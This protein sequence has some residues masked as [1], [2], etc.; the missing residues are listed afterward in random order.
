MDPVN[1]EKAWNICRFNER[2]CPVKKR[3]TE[4]KRLSYVLMFDVFF[5]VICICIFFSTNHIR[6]KPNCLSTSQILLGNLD[7][8]KQSDIILLVLVLVLAFD[9]VPHQRLL[10]KLSPLMFLIYIND[11]SVNIKSHIRLFAEDTLLYPTVSSK[12][13]TNTLKQDLDSLVAWTKL[14]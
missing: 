5:F 9:T 4:G 11:I 1:C 6:V 8:G 12:D 14:W 7:H 10:L 3:P 13:D 2:N